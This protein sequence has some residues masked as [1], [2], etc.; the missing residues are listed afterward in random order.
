MP[1]LN[2][3]RDQLAAF[4]QNMPDD[5]PILMLNL[6]RYRE[7]ADYPPDSGYSPCSGREA[8]KRYSRIALG[9]VQ[10]AGGQVE[11][12]AQA[13]TALIAPRDEQWH[14]LLLVRYPS[15]AAFLGMLADP[16]YRAAT[17]HRTAAL[18]DSRL[19]GCL[20]PG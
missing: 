5:T 9:K 20:P 2:P 12:M 6:L 10:D 17:V 19:I 14:D 11:L 8:Y 16:E 18:A 3:S 4:A 1:S 13:Q 7:S 15:K